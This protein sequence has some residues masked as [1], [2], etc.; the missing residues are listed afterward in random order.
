M[1]IFITLFG[2]MV[3]NTDSIDKNKNNFLFAFL[4]IHTTDAVYVK[5]I[6]K[7]DGELTITKEFKNLVPEKTE[8]KLEQKEFSKNEK[9]LKAYS[10]IKG[11][12]KQ[13]LC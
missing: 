7:K 3:A 4:N 8:L 1:G 11:K 12:F 9:Q 2:V 5:K 10:I 13:L 6:E